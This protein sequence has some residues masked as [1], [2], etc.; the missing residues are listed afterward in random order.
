PA[1]EGTTLF[2]MGQGYQDN[3]S[4]LDPHRPLHRWTAYPLLGQTAANATPDLLATP[5]LPMA[6]PP[7]FA[8][9]LYGV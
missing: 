1:F 8:E 3:P 9:Q 4:P 5:S 6:L 2:V 7:E